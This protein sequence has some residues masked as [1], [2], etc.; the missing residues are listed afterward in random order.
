MNVIVRSRSKTG[1]FRPAQPQGTRHPA[2]HRGSRIL[3]ITCEIAQKG[4]GYS[5]HNFLNLV[6][7]QP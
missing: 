1:A 5:L 6:T 4:E 7:E 2:E 3:L